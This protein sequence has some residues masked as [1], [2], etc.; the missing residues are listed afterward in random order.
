MIYLQNIT[1]AVKIEDDAPAD[2]FDIDFSADCGNGMQP[3]V[4]ECHG[5]QISEDVA[6]QIDITLNKDSCRRYHGQSYT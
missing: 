3:G 2:V 1:S 5:I 4:S 6:F